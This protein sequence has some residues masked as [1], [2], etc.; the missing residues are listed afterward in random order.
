MQGFT[1]WKPVLFNVIQSDIWTE[2]TWSQFF[3]Y[4]Y[5]LLYT[6]GLILSKQ[7][8]EDGWLENYSYNLLHVT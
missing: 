1:L 4:I 3:V 8:R 6:A 2:M 5:V 7:S